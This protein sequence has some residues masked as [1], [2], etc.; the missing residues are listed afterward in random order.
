MISAS[1]RRLLC[2]ARIPFFIQRK[3]APALEERWLYSVRS[4]RVLLYKSFFTHLERRH[5]RSQVHTLI[6]CTDQYT[7]DIR[8]HNIGQS[9]YSYLLRSNPSLLL[10][11]SDHFFIRCL[12]YFHRFNHACSTIAFPQKCCVAVILQIISE[13]ISISKHHFSSHLL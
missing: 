6:K 13:S 10:G 1:S 5:A 8:S 9:S 2:L 11:A 7:I 4:F 12:F 3:I